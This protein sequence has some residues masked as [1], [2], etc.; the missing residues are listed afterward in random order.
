MKEILL[1]ITIILLFGFVFGYIPYVNLN[2]PIPDI[3]RTNYSIT[4]QG[5]APYSYSQNPTVQPI[6]SI[7]YVFPTQNNINF[8]S[9]GNITLS[10]NKKNSQIILGLKTD[11]NLVAADV[12]NAQ[13][14]NGLS[15]NYYLNYNNLNNL[16][17]LSIYSLY[18][19]SN[20]DS[21]LT[22]G[23][24][25]DPPWAT[26]GTTNIWA[27]I[28]NGDW[29]AVYARFS[30]INGIYQL[31]ADMNE[32]YYSQLDANAALYTKID[33][34]AN[35]VPY[36]GATMHAVLGNYSLLAKDLNASGDLNILGYARIGNG[37]NMH[38][39]LQAGDL[40]I[41][42][43]LY[44]Q[45]DAN[46]SKNATFT[47]RVGIGTTAPTAKLSVAGSATDN[48]YFFYDN[49][50]VG[51]T[52]D[53]QSLYVYRRAAEGDGYLQFYT[54]QWNE[55]YIDTPSS[56]STVKIAPS[57]LGW[58]YVGANAKVLL[59]SNAASNVELFTS[60]A[61]GENR[62]LYTY[63]YD[64]GASATKYG[65]FNVD[66]VGD[67]DIEAQSGEVIRFLT[68][69]S[70]RVTIDNAGKVGIGTTTPAHKLTVQG[71]INA[72]GFL[73]LGNGLDMNIGLNTGDFNAS[74]KIIAS[75]FNISNT[76]TALRKDGNITLTSPD[77]TRYNCGVINGGSFVC[78]T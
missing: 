52:T 26:I 1:V 8:V 17:N 41:A 24:I 7:N 74:G 4:G 25:A 40:N 37:T 35:F 39:G 15:G 34:N 66:A 9:D 3:N 51:D 46:F 60:A 22:Y 68:G 23:V 64:T 44:V 19:D 30:D 76:K 33:A 62:Y 31:K 38:I 71:D 28:L 36:I 70:D 55:A 45:G 57:T 77:G 29:N 32:Q 67:F 27:W 11:L 75:D 59:S 73:I 49:D 18:A 47:G 78:N 63:G 10:L 50:D 20:N 69:G 58:V 61:S 48:A 42:R 65:R 21:R 56:T 53:G 14:L 12:N 54:N 43:N 16:P 72:S 5:T 2:Q 13:F 6:N